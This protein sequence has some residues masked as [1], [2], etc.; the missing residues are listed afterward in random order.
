[1]RRL[2]FTLAALFV[3]ASFLSEPGPA[4]AQTLEHGYDDRTMRGPGTAL[5]AV[6]YTPGLVREGAPITATP[7]VIDDLQAAGWDVFRFIPPG[8]GDIIEVAAAALA[9]AA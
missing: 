1:M 5:G 4:A 7:Y 9:D 3:C 6:I 8:A 2:L